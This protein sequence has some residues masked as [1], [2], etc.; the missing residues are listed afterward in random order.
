VT[1]EIVGSTD[2]RG[3]TSTAADL[4]AFVRYP[5]RGGI[6]VIPAG[7]GRR[8][9]LTVRHG[10]PWYFSQ[11]HPP[12]WS[13]DGK[14]IAF[15]DSRHV[16]KSHDCLTDDDYECP[17]EI[18]VIRPDGTGER[19]IT[20]PSVGVSPPRWSPDGRMLVYSREGRL[21]LIS[22]DTTREGRLTRVEKPHDEGSP[23]WAPD[24]RKVA[25]VVDEDVYISDLHGQLRRVSNLKWR[26][27]G[28]IRALVWSPDGEWIAF[29]AYE[30]YFKGL[31]QIFIVKP[32]G[33]D[34]RRL[35]RA[36]PDPYGMSWSP[37]GTRIAYGASGAAEG[38]LFTVSVP[39]G[40]IHRLR[41]GP[42]L[43]NWSDPSWSRS[44]NQ[45]VATRSTSG[46]PG[47]C[48]IINVSTGSARRIVTEGHSCTWQPTR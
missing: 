17:A 39:S 27:V 26:R 13:P 31:E 46:N 24:G 42:G 20:S 33:G 19:Q 45:L 9:D 4:V 2:G 7:G 11:R 37:D 22:L 18:Y 32:N 25:L 14:W 40:R 21:R 8:R 38:G 48:W 44:G 5:G 23:S 34:Q 28:P 35:T 1:F 36:H 10:A 16:P 41:A 6:S 30:P 29:S 3:G 15:V 43:V 12:V 47:G